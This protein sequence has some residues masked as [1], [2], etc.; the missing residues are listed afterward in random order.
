M[1]END[2]VYT[3][4]EVSAHVFGGSGESVMIAA[5]T[6]GTVISI[7]SGQGFVEVEFIDHEFPADYPWGRS[8][9]AVLCP[10]EWE[11]R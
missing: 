2:L 1:Q 5:G 10:G 3:L 7:G 6:R 11:E 8:S 9:T 4:T